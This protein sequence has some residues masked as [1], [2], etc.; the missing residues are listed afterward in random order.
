M[1]DHMRTFSLR[2][3][4]LEDW[5][6]HALFLLLGIFLYQY[7][8]WFGF[9]WL[10]ETRSA[11][12]AAMV[13]T[14]LVHWLLR[15]FGWFAI[16]VWL[17]LNIIWIAGLVDPR[18]PDRTQ[19]EELPLFGALGEYLS[20]F[21]PYVW[22]ALGTGVIYLGLHVYLK[23][24][25]RIFAFMA[26][27]VVLFCV[28]DS[29]STFQLWDQVAIIIASGLTM[30]VIHHFATFKRR[31]PEGYETL[32]A[33]PAPIL[34]MI[35][36]II[37]ASILLGV[38]APSI[39]PLI[40]DPYTAWKTYQGETVP[41]FTSGP[42]FSP[43]STG[44]SQS[45]YSR[46][47]AVLGGSFQYD[48][49]PVFTVET[50]HRSYWR[51]ETR[52]YYNGNGWE[53]TF[54]DQEFF[55]P[56]SES[57]ESP[58]EALQIDGLET[59]EVTQTFQFVEGQSFP[60]LFAA[61]YAQQ[62]DDVFTGENEVRL[63]R[64]WW[65]TED[66]TLL[67][68]N[69]R[70]S[71][72]YPLLY[73]ITS[74]VPVLDE[75]TLKQSEPVKDR[76]AFAPYLQVPDN[77]PERV[78]QLAE[79]V[80]ADAPTPY[81]KAKALETYLSTTYVYSNTPDLTKRKSEDFVDSF[82][83]EVKEGYCDYFSTAMVI[84]ARTL[85]LPA[86]WVKGF[87]SGQLIADEF[88]WEMYLAGEEAALDG[89]GTYTVRNA[90]AHSWVEIY[91]EGYGWVPFEPT[92]GFSFPAVQ[93]EHETEVTLPDA[94]ADSETTG[95]PVQQQQRSWGGGAAAAGGTVLALGILF[96]CAVRF[97]WL[98]FLKT[99]RFRK[100]ANYNVKFLADV[101]RLL[102][103][104]RRKGLSWSEHETFREMMMRWMD[105][106]SWLQ[107]DLEPLLHVFEKAKYS[108]AELTE[109]EYRN[110]EQ[111]IRRLKEIL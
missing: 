70:G 16:G 87:A 96:Y 60:V 18:W 4:L 111:H 101:D 65:N 97:Q 7:V 19:R 26:Y 31:N 42:G 35:V 30:L 13:L 106:Y 11:V 95:S 37:S 62:V 54:P 41:A 29:F 8:I 80:T 103:R 20:P 88:M 69:F 109:E 108:G 77:L 50:S 49:S 14:F 83:F 78:K 67:H 12:T 100:S 90:D 63:Q 64:I 40:M 107:D 56:L 110:A 53:V 94:I 39:R 1:R 5:H 3:W 79:E 66:N 45:G 44:N 102:L 48:Y 46:D 89:P 93:A 84:M 58:D 57:L 92:A 105:Q 17:L 81:E 51:G 10:E 23:T 59:I 91:F 43:F 32:M 2:R 15:R 72:P 25:W 75:E 21:S 98:A 47:D 85:D 24:R 36:T 104:F 71:N 55:I 61:P 68:P 27:S 33:Y 9:Y 76:E 38:L 28:V 6:E 86:R 34:V 22:F 73:T 52:S 82:L 99:R 74:Y